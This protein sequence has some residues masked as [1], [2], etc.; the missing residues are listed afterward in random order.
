MKIVSPILDGVSTTAH[1]EGC[2]ERM[3]NTNPV[4]FHPISLARPQ[5]KLTQ[6]RVGALWDCEKQQG[7]RE[8]K[9]SRRVMK[10]DRGVV[11]DILK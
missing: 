11:G 5:Q 6:I 4:L 3:F 2:T 10:Q 8:E 7:R 1:L 9:R